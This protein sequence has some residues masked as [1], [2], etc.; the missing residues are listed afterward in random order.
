MHPA[1]PLRNGC[2]RPRER[3]TRERDE[4]EKG[5]RRDKV[6]ERFKKI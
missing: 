2:D 1:L 3:E 5:Q 4:S 6:E